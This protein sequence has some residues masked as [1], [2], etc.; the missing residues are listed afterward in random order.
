MRPLTAA[1]LGA[2]ETEYFVAKGSGFFGSG[3]KIRMV[4]PDQRNVPGTDGDILK[5]GARTGEGI[6]PSVTIGSETDSD[7]VE[8]GS[9]AD[10]GEGA[11]PSRVALC[12]RR[13]RRA[14]QRHDLQDQR[15]A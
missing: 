11:S 7:R 3:V 1:A 14:E 2:I 9:G 10:H 8:E 12:R 15:C 6:R 4:V 13:H 5:N